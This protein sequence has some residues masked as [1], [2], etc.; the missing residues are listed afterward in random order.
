VRNEVAVGLVEEDIGLEQ[1]DIFDEQI[2]AD[3]YTD[4]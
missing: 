2:D 4:V 1:L 3:V